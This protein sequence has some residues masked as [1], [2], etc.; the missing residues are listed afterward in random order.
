MS[1]LEKVIKGLECCEG[2]DDI[3]HCQECP[4]D[5]RCLERDSVN[6]EP[7]PLL[8]DALEWLKKLA[9]CNHDCKIDCLLESFN[10]VVAERDELLEKQKPVKPMAIRK[11]ELAYIM[12]GAVVW[13]D[14]QT[15]EWSEV[16]MPICPVCVEGVGITDWNGKQKVMIQ[17]TDGY[18]D[19]ADYGKGYRLWTAR[20]T[21]EQ[22]R[23]EKWN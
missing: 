2:T 17:Y 23:G 8:R 16:L 1:D 13:Y 5:E 21:D 15:S 9:K 7:S 10:K 18:D 19:V 3:C 11:D 4:Y 12:P 20:P 14:E 6:G 22:R